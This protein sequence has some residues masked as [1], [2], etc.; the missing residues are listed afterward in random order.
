MGIRHHTSL[1]V[2]SLGSRPSSAALL[3]GPGRVAN[4]SEPQLHR[5]NTMSSWGWPMRKAL[6]RSGACGAGI[7]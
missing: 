2:R 1:G 4:L 3:C 7:L 6:K 5:A